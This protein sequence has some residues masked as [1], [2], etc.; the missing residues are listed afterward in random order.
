M[1]VD[2]A[3]FNIEILSIAFGSIW[4]SEPNANPS[5]ITKG[6]FEDEK[7]LNPRTLI[8]APSAPGLPDCC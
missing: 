7:E 6:L 1:A 2:A 3:S 4:S 8:L 5:I